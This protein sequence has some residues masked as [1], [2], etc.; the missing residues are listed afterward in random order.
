MG[1]VV[2]PKLPCARRWELAPWEAWQHLSYPEPG[3]ERWGHETHGGTRAAL[4]QAVGASATRGVAAP[5]QP[6]P[7][8]ITQC[9][10]HVGVYEHTSFPSS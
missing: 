5:E 10:G 8:G 4:S 9:H 1:H 7:G 6:M 2:A 3:L